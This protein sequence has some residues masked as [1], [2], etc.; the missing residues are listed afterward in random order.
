MKIEPRKI[1]VMGPF[2]TRSGYGEQSRFALRALRTRPDLFDIYLKPL[3]WGNTSWIEQYDSEKKWIDA[4]VVKT[5]NY[6]AEC[7]REQKI[8][9]HLSLQ[10]T[11]PNEFQKITP[12]NI[13]Y[14]AGIETTLVSGEWIQ[15][16]NQID[17]LL[18]ISK[19]AKKVFEESKYTQ[20]LPS[21]EEVP[22]TATTPISVVSYPV[23]DIVPSPPLDLE[24]STDFNFL[25][26]AQFGPRKNLP[27]TINW[28]VEE[29]HDENVGLILKSNLMRNSLI[30]RE[31]LYLDIRRGLNHSFPDRKCKVY[32]LHGDLSES[33]IASLYC[34]PKMNAFY[35]LPHG[36]G[37]GLPLFEAAY[38]GMPVVSIGFSGQ[39][40]FLC[41][42]EGNPHFYNV[43][44]EINKIQPECVWDKVLV[45]ESGWA[46]PKELSAK[47]QLRQCYEDILSNTGI[48]A[49][50]KNYALELKSR[51]DQDK[52]YES[53][54]KEVN[55]IWDTEE[56]D[57]G[58][59]F[60]EEWDT[61]DL[62]NEIAAIKE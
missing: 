4:T 45:A 22:F 7:N 24:I 60:I 21:G 34:H 23:K 40:D 17:K 11:I 10:I 48:A 16:I 31:K 33:E 26:V 18:V 14:T 6:I 37:F 9:F 36:E 42:E 2:L 59:S 35:M 8:P 61:E 53:F 27:Q 30:D 39:T 32:L 25:C 44:F 19:H 3:P 58:L 1:L 55:Y 47:K 15:A 43:D 12:I 20:T 29:F 52:M 56:L 50:A 5:N 41:D 46:Y 57:S 38:S 54:V 28:F 51:F 49:D 62:D 13:G